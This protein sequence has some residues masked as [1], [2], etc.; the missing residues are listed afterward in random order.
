MNKLT[1]LLFLILVSSCSYLYHHSNDIKNS[2]FK[3][4]S[5]VEAYKLQGLFSF[6]GNKKSLKGKLNFIFVSE[7]KFWLSIR[8]PFN[9]ELF[10]VVCLNDSLYQIN[11]VKKEYQQKSIKNIKEGLSLVEQKK[12]EKSIKKIS[13]FLNTDINFKDKNYRITFSDFRSNYNQKF[14]YKI[15]IKDDSKE[16]ITI[17]VDIQKIENT[18]QKIMLKIPGSYEKI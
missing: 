18:T 14:P 3:N 12:F 8:S 6:K 11:N 2:N 16:L 13:S 17:D 10:K 4:K 5:N 15:N 9:I 1:F 7:E